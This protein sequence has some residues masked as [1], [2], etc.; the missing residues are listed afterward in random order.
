MMAFWMILI[1]S[2]LE[3]VWVGHEG[4]TDVQVKVV[5]ISIPTFR[6]FQPEMYCALFLINTVSL[7]LP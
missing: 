2:G 3:V 4:C 7:L 1:V 6:E 5:G